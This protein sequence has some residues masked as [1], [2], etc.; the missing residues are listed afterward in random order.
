MKSNLS[1]SQFLEILKQK[2]A[3]E[4]YQNQLN[5]LKMKINQHN[6]FF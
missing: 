4:D 2:K 6:S 5:Q 3:V 1:T